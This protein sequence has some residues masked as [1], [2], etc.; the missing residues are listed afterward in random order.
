[1]SCHKIKKQLSAYV[2]G[3]LPV[4][5]RAAVKLHVGACADCQRELAALQEIS[6][7]LAKLPEV[8]APDGFLADVCEELQDTGN[9]GRP[10]FSDWLL[11]PLWLKIPLQAAATVG[12][13]AGIVW[14]VQSRQTATSTTVAA[15]P[16]PIT[17]VRLETSVT[18]DR[19]ATPPPPPALSPAPG[20]AA[21]PPAVTDGWDAALAEK[22]AK[23]EGADRSKKSDASSLA[24]A[25]KEMKSKDAPVPAAPVVAAHGGKAVSPASETITI[26]HADA[27]TVRARATTLLAGLG[28]QVLPVAKG[29]DDRTRF[30][31]ELPVAHLSAFKTQLTQQYALQ[32]AGEKALVAGRPARLDDLRSRGWAESRDESAMPAGAPATSAPS[33]APAP[34]AYFSRPT[35]ANLRPSAAGGSRAKTPMP[36]H[37][38]HGVARVLIE[39]EVIP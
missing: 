29:S 31:V 2:D 3:E 25:A 5:E 15:K 17:V 21:T 14:L 38:G 20:V 6:A 28:G 26:R 27:A 13:L 24:A 11:R 1:M 30:Q 12:I 19:V 22:L 10:S 8:T 9:T 18:E 34:E 33:N 4:A 16:A 39:I 35:E 32:N 37:E 7:R 36:A 23:P